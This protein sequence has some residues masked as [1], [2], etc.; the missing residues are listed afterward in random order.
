M[1]RRQILT[2]AG[3]LAGVALTGCGGGEIAGGDIGSEI[4]AFTT[5]PATLVP[6]D[7]HYQIEV[8]FGLQRAAAVHMTNNGDYLAQDSNGNLIP[9]ASKSITTGWTHRVGFAK[10]RV[11]NEPIRHFAALGLVVVEQTKKADG[12]YNSWFHQ[13]GHPVTD[14]TVWSTSVR[15]ERDEANDAYI[16]EFLSA[17]PS[18]SPTAKKM[19]C[20]V[21][22]YR[23]PA[24]ELYDPVSAHFEPTADQYLRV[25]PNNAPI[26]NLGTASTLRSQHLPTVHSHPNHESAARKASNG[27]HQDSI[28]LQDPRQPD[29]FRMIVPTLYHATPALRPMLERV[30][31]RHM[32]RL[33]AKQAIG[34]PINYEGDHD[35]HTAL[36]SNELLRLFGGESLIENMRSLRTK[37]FTEAEAL[38]SSISGEV[39]AFCEGAFADKANQTLQDDANRMLQTAKSQIPNA[40]ANETRWAFSMQ[41]TVAF[42]VSGTVVMKNW[43]L[44]GVDPGVAFRLSQPVFRGGLTYGNGQNFETDV[45]LPVL[46]PHEFSFVGILK[47]INA[48]SLFSIDIEFTLNFQWAEDKYVMTSWVFDPVFDM[49]L[50][51]IGGR[52]TD[53]G[54][55]AMAKATAADN[56]F[57]KIL[58]YIP[59]ELSVKYEVEV[60]ARTYSNAFDLIPLNELPEPLRYP[61]SESLKATGNLTNPTVTNVLE[62]SPCRFKFAHRDLGTKFTATTPR[63]VFGGA[64]SHGYCPSVKWIWGAIYRTSTKMV[65]EVAIPGEVQIAMSGYGRVVSVLD[66]GAV[67][68]DQAFYKT[69][70][71]IPN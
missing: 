47:L 57:A 55:R 25:I 18:L 66:I 9:L 2:A 53:T 19:F 70:S 44:Y 23:L 49:D 68:G 37:L 59:S 22:M 33:G 13:C 35:E 58:T 16:W 61:L 51:S 29:N 38:F 6:E 39:N 17:D 26:G 31:H 7:G 3:A 40:T 14:G 10:L 4:A 52:L 46:K 71:L 67:F 69:V 36:L 34:D 56:P 62:I 11:T 50:R 45:Y 65:P 27:T 64:K 42:Q 20:S 24:T 32:D 43:P 30:L 8:V 28:V 5:P 48:A 12:T 60:L 15:Y 63:W 54:L 21:R 41:E 1:K